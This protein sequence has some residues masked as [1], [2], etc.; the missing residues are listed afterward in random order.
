MRMRRLE[1]WGTAIAAIGVLTLTT[2]AQ[3]E[4]AARAEPAA[5]VEQ[6]G[7]EPPDD[8]LGLVSINLGGFGFF[9]PS[10]SGELGGKV[11]GH[12]GVRLFS[13][14]ALSHALFVEEG[15]SIQTGSLG[16]SLGAR[17]YFGQRRFQGWYAG[18]AAELL[19]LGF[20]GERFQTVVSRRV[21]VP[22]AEG[23]YRLRWGSLLL[24]FGARMGYS[25][26]LSNG[27]EALGAAPITCTASEYG[28]TFYGEGVL[29]VGVVF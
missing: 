7:G 14:G 9:G 25:F 5:A 26:E 10:L 1:V 19:L 8:A 3:A 2:S 4:E 17:Y 29:D 24:G 23:G 21:L 15:D 28:D 27:C 12:A 6:P 16:V 22:L 13:L 11:T 18:A 20:E